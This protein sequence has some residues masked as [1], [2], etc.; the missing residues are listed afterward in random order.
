[1]NFSE[2]FCIIMLTKANLLIYNFQFPIKS[3]KSFAVPVFFS[4][5]PKR[6]GGA[7]LPTTELY[8]ELLNC[9]F[10]P[11][12]CSCRIAECFWIDRLGFYL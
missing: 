9:C 10:A 6:A 7:N 5:F 11:K 1:M 4:F 2:L 8:D 3:H 12:Q